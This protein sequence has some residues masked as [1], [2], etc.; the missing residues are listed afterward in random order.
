MRLT[1]EQLA[2]FEEKGYLVLRKFAEE[3]LCDTILDIAK[4]H[5]KHQVPPVETEL[6]YVGKSKEERKTISDGHAQE[7]EQHITVRRLRQVYHRDIV[8]REWMESQKIRPILKQILK[9]NP[10]ITIAHHNSIMTKMPHTST[11]TRWH[12]DIRYWH[13]ENDNLV[14]VWLALDEENDENGVLEFIPGSHKMTFR[15]EQFDEKEY[16]ADDSAN[17]HMLIK[18]KEQ[19]VLQKG[20]VVF[21][22][23]KLL[24]RAN[25]NRTEIPKISFVYT[26][27][28][29]S[30]HP[31]SGTRSGS[32]PEVALG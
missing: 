23:S 15:A 7:R 4:A 32:F 12:Q 20:D 17:N 30:N 14:S 27:H 22:H 21:F 19:T 6:E 3:E 31:I 10:V 1:E 16:F 9:E 5:L 11:E 18:T 13:F 2:R 26:V 29:K 8:F 24:H 28:G 25:K